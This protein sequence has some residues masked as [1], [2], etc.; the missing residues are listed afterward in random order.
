[1]SS[2]ILALGSN[3]GNSLALLKQ[4]VNALRAHVHI[5]Q[6]SPVFETPPLLPPDAPAEW[7]RFF[8]NATVEIKTELPPLELLKLTQKIER[9]LGR[10]ERHSTWSPRTMDID[11]LFSADLPHYDHSDL[12]LPHPA[13]SQR[14]FVVSPLIH[15]KNSPPQAREAFLR[16]PSCTPALMATLNVTPDSF[17]NTPGSRDHVAELESLLEL[18]PAYIDIGAEST[19]PGATPLTAEDE[20][21]RLEPVLAIWRDRHAQHPFTRISLDTYHPDTAEKARDYRVTTLNDVTGLKNPRLREVAADYSEVIVM[22]SL[23][24]PADKQITWPASTDVVTELQQWWNAVRDRTAFLSDSQIIFD[25]GLGFGKTSLQSLEI[26]QRL[27]E[28]DFVQC[29]RLIGH[30]R[31]SFQSLWTEA[32]FA[33]RDLETLGVSSLL[34]QKSVEIL[35]VHNL[36]WHQRFFRSAQ[37]VRGFHEDL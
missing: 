14:S 24:I 3:Q 11:L 16:I 37:A 12:Q 29:R 34:Q 22:H 19:R 36:P 17:S 10:P 23:G 8:L 27:D 18:S 15:L 26:L 31:K 5:A 35:R 9:D 2:Y 28:M 4:A 25:P 33:D 13:W 21:R 6:V 7:Y 30:S 32:P 1:M 20:W